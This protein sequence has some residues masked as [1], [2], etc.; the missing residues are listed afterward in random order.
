MK[1]TTAVV[2]LASAV[3]VFRRHESPC[4]Y[5]RR[6]TVET[7]RNAA[8][9]LLLYLVL[10]VVGAVAISVMESLP[11]MACLFET[12]SAIGTVGLT[13]GL[14]PGL[15]L[16][17]RLILIALMFFG[18]VGGLTLIF[19]TFSGVKPEVSRLPRGQITVG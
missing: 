15:C 8:A 5:G 2:L 1:I 14:T 18:R 11:M 19:A 7:T 10:P 17:S 16:G 9:I 6:I 4:L 3:A 13:L 12:A